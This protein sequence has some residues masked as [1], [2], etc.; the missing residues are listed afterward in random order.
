[1]TQPARSFTLKSQAISDRGLNERRPLNEDSFLADSTR[2]IFVVADGVGGAEAGEVAS[3]T[4]VEVLDEAFRHQE[5]GADIED[6]MELAIQRAN[7]S[8]HQ[9]AQD[10]ARFSMM[11][12]TVVALHLKGNVATIGHVGDSRLYRLTPEGDIVRE[13]ED[14]SVVEEEVRAGRMTAEQAANHPSKNVISRALGAEDTVEVDLKTFEVED[15]TEFLLCTDGITRHISDGELRQLL[16][17]HDD[18]DALCK[19]LKQRCYERGAED[20]LTAVVVRC[21]GHILAHERAE[22]LQRTISPET[23]MFRAAAS[24]PAVAEVDLEDRTLDALVPPSRTSFPAADQSAPVTRQPLNI[25]EREHNSGGFAK[26]VGRL[27]LFLMFLAVVAAAFYGGRRYKGPIPFLKEPAD[28]L[29]QASPSPTAEDPQAKFERTRAD[30]D[31]EPQAWLSGEMT[32]ELAAQNILNPLDSVDPGFLYLYGRASMLSGNSADAAKAFEQAIIRSA[33]AP[34]PTNA[35]VKKD[36]TLALA[37]L[38]LKSDPDKAKALTYLD[39]LVPK[40]SPTVSP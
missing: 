23:E 19:E 36:A 13:T 17:I 21:G 11:A 18:L 27:V 37:A 10:N 22:D 16:V 39:D 25:P 26:S 32:R 6:L 20:N 3:K 34:S 33:A 38:A 5:E 1:M 7:A 24:A 35:T 14:H 31:S 9:M 12:T 2:R 4:A 29:V 8:I 40:P 30:I 28:A 15:G